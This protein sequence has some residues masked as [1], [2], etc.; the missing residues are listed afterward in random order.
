MV[1]QVF[2]MLINEVW[3]VGGGRIDERGQAQRG[4]LKQKKALA[5]SVH[6]GQEGGGGNVMW[7]TRGP[8]GL[9]GSVGSVWVGVAVALNGRE[10]EQWVIRFDAIVVQRHL[11]LMCSVLDWSPSLSGAHQKLAG[12]LNGCRES[13]ECA[14]LPLVGG[15]GLLSA[16]MGLVGC[17]VNNSLASIL[18][19]SRSVLFTPPRAR[20]LP[21]EIDDGPQVSLVRQAVAQGGMQVCE[22]RERKKGPLFP[23]PLIRAHFLVSIFGPD[24]SRCTAQPDEHHVGAL[25]P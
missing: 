8:V 22:A 23:E 4:W 1:V 16:C 13:C 10:R 15:P 24:G 3:R 12:N 20:P 2:Q 5:R 19:L 18:H 25:I 7:S 17:S 14:H 6:T 9:V 11:R 21:I